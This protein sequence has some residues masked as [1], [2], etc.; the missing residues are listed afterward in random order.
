M[1]IPTHLQSRVKKLALKSWVADKQFPRDHYFESID[2]YEERLAGL[3]TAD[4]YDEAT[5]NRSLAVMLGAELN[6]EGAL[7]EYVV[8]TNTHDVEDD[9]EWTLICEAAGW[10]VLQLYERGRKR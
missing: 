6:A 5:A 7:N 4:G 9:Q 2:T 1:R 3:K 10:C 8:E